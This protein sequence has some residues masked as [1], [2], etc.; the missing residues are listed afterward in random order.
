MSEFAKNA[1]PAIEKRTNRKPFSK[2]YHIAN[3]LRSGNVDV[4]L[5]MEIA[6]VFCLMMTKLRYSQNSSTPHLFF[7]CQIMEC[8]IYVFNSQ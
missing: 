8:A 3:L 4:Y 6:T 5:K 2:M 7:N 1:N